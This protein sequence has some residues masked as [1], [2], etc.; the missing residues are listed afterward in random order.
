MGS[1]DVSGRS[2]ADTLAISVAT[3]SPPPPTVF[4]N[5]T[6]FVAKG[7]SN[8]PN[9]PWA[10]Y[11]TSTFNTGVATKDTVQSKQSI[12]YTPPSP[13][14]LGQGNA[15]ISVP[16]N[17]PNSTTLNYDQ[18]LWITSFQTGTYAQ[19]DNVQVH[20][21]MVWF[22][23][24]RSEVF[25]Q[26]TIAWPL[27]STSNN[28]VVRGR[29]FQDMQKFQD[30]IR[31]HQQ[32]SALTSSFPSPLSLTIYNNTGSNSNIHNKSQTISDDPL[33]SKNPS[34]LP[35]HGN[36][37]TLIN[38][39]I[40]L[41]SNSITRTDPSINNSP[42]LPNSLTTPQPQPLIYQ[43]WIETVSKQYTRFKSFYTM[44]YRMNVLNPDTEYSH[45]LIDSSSGGNSLIPNSWDVKQYG[46]GWYGNSLG[47][48]GG[49][50]SSSQ[51]VG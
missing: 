12:P 27:Q 41:T 37:Q 4:T 14:Q 38:Q 5:Y 22:P 11:G 42:R 43:G 39:S 30:I 1:H 13:T 36:N 9:N 31:V 24:R 15:L 34:N 46:Q 50:L 32:Q 28:G 48:N 2:H 29:N 40:A 7:T 17:Q 8:D 6:G 10:N 3:V 25:V 19:Y 47:L 16:I 45:L 44:T 33:I 18:N 49:I 35:I 20:R 21:G 26:F 51:I 23:I